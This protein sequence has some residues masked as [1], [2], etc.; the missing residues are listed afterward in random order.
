MS[1]CKSICLFHSNRWSSFQQKVSGAGKAEVP[2]YPP[3]ETLRATGWGRQTANRG[4]TSPRAGESCTFH[5]TAEGVVR[6]PSPTPF[7]DAAAKRIERWAE[8]ERRETLPGRL[9]PRRVTR[10]AAPACGHQTFKLLS[11][12]ALTLRV[13]KG[14]PGHFQP[15]WPPFIIDIFSAPQKQQL[16]RGGVLRSDPYV[17]ESDYPK[18][19][20]LLGGWKQ[21]R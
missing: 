20:K 13:N 16:T 14:N 3:T 2:H 5:V 4:E 17:R 11:S 19:H 10:Q 18:L 9:L 21:W 8:L 6:V 1:F 15:L 12:A 7:S